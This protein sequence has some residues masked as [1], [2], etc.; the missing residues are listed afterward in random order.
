MLQDPLRRLLIAILH[1]DLRNDFFSSDNLF[2]PI[3]IWTVFPL[4]Y[5]DFYS[6]FYLDFYFFFEVLFLF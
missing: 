3:S 6:L 2:F 4:F 1:R 5:L